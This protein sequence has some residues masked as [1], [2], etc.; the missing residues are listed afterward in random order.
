[1]MQLAYAIVWWLVLLVIGLITFPL[2]SRVCNRLPDKGYSISKI[3]GLVLVTY[4]S[5][6]LASTHLVKFGYFNLSISFVLLLVLSLFLGRKYLTRKGLPWKS[7][8]ISEAVFSATFLLFLVFLAYRPDIDP[9][10]EDFMDFA[11]M[12]SILRTDYLPPHDPWLAGENIL[13]YYGGH[14]VSAIMAMISRVPSA[15]AY[16]LAVAM[17]FALAAGASYGLGYNVTKR[18]L[19]GFVAVVFVCIA[20]W[21]S[22]AFQL[23]AYFLQQDVA[24]YSPTHAP[25]I[26]EWLRSADFVSANWLIKYAAIRN[27]FYTFSVGSLHADT[28]DI[29]FQLM[30]IVLIFA[31]FKKSD[32]DS[33]ITKYDSLLS[34]FIIGLSL[35]FLSFVNMWG[36]PTYL[37]FAVLAF[38]LLRINISKK[39]IVGIVALSL[40]LYLPYYIGRGMGGVN[41][42][43]VGGGRTELLEFLKIFPL[44][45]FAV[46][47]LFYVSLKGRLIKGEILVLTAIFIIVVAL[48]SFLFNFQLILVLAP[49]ILVPLYC[50]Y[51][52]RPKKEAEFMLLLVMMGALIVLGCEIF[53]IDDALS[54]PWQRFN[55]L[56]K[57]YIQI[58]I[59]LG[60]ASAYAVYWVLEN[61]KGKLKSLWACLLVVL[62]LASLICPV[63]LIASWTSSEH[64]YMGL[65]RGTLDGIAYIETSAPGDYEAIKWLNANIK[66]QPVI[67]EAPGGAYQ[68][69]SHISTM[70]GLP[71]VI[72]WLTH[73]VMWR[74]SWDEVSGRDMDVDTIY[75]T[76]NNEEAF[77]LLE[78]YNVEYIYIGDLE[79]QR[80]KEEGLKKFAAYLEVYTLIY[81]NQGVKIYQVM[82]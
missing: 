68:F 80:Y 21:L 8:L 47:S 9:L 56:A 82:R 77:S 31:L 78:K 4:F 72:G 35:G 53:F 57:F 63:G 18:K 49:L 16:N 39:S 38:L 14:M 70:T 2:V 75:Q 40:L 44:F 17:F 48:V 37:I 7:M 12:Q 45:L 73:E 55:T 64:N 20:G 81:E 43:G 22:G 27:P 51:K 13:Y 15:I 58:W 65:N 52:A 5:F 32:S 46:F 62:V 79:K 19:Y 50:I 59:F 67:L 34:V 30:F 66:G 6:L 28:T 61:T 69:T 24:G 26:I 36:Y 10:S 25:N 41:S 76:T 42:I 54:A 23:A 74:N 1:M 33:K 3:L 60:I 71:T 11:F 29:P